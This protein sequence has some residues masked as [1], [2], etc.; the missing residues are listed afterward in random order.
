MVTQ[1]CQQ[2]PTLSIE[3]L[4]FIAGSQEAMPHLTSC[5]PNNDSF[6]SFIFHYVS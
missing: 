5:N 2:Y 4:Q 6:I 1:R 3:T